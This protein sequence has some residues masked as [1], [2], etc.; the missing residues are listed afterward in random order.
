MTTVLLLHGIA[1]SATTWWRA[2]RDLTDLGIEVVAPSLPGHGG[3]PAAVRPSIAAQADAVRDDLA[4]R[5]VDLVVG[6]SLGALVALTLAAQAQDLV[7]RVLLED[8]PSLG[9]R[10]PREVAGDLAGE[11]AAARRDPV[12]FE[13]ALL[14]ANPTWSPLDVRAA[15]ANRQV[16][17]VAAAEALLDAG[18]WDLLAL[19]GA[20][21][22]PV[23]LLAA[24]APGTALTDPDRRELLDL[25]ED[26]A[27]VV[28][29][30]HSVHRDRPALW[31]HAVL[32]AL[33]A[34]D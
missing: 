3:R 32:T 14:A 29:S 15:A 2:Q 19:V 23:H 17:D 1:S 8:P 18:R 24:T 4:G 27:L 33:E 30:G 21:P 9:D 25:L 7:P 12:A 28:E 13:A 31:L 5:P 16:L 34:D 6:H 11:A 10:S 26:R 22:A 20:C